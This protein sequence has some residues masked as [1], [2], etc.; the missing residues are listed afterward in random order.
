MYRKLLVSAVLLCKCIVSYGQTTAIPESE[1][2]I[3]YSKNVKNYNELL[4][5]TSKQ[6]ELIKAVK[7]TNTGH[8][9][10]KTM[11][12][13]LNLAIVNE[14]VL[15]TGGSKWFEFDIA[16]SANNSGTFLDISFIKVGY[17]TGVFGSS[18]TTNGN[19]VV[20]PASVLNIPS[21]NPLAT[22]V[23]DN[24]ASEVNLPISTS[25]TF[26]PL[27]R[28]QVTTTATTIMTVRMKIANCNQAYNLSFTSQAI[29]ANFS[30]FSPTANASGT[31]TTI[32]GYDNVNFSGNITDQSCQ[33]IITAWTNGVP[34]GESKT[35]SVTGKYFGNGKLNGAAL[36]F[37]NAVYGDR[38]PIASNTNKGGIQAIDLV[39]WNHNQIVIVLPSIIDSADAYVQGN[40]LPVLNGRIR[41]GSGKFK[42][43]N[44]VQGQAESSGPIYIPWNVTQLMDNHIII[45]VRYRKV[46]PRLINITGG[47]YR[48]LINNHINNAW[49][50][51][52]A[53]PVI[54]KAMK[55]WSCATGINWYIGGDTTKKYAGQ[56]GI[57]VIDTAN[58]GALMETRPTIRECTMSNGQVK[59]YLESF[60]IL[61]KQVPQAGNYSMDTSSNIPY[62]SYDFYSAISHELGH[63]HRQSHIND[64]IVDL[65]WWQANPYG[66][67]WSNRKL[68]KGSPNAVSGGNFVTDSLNGTVDD[69]KPGM[70]LI[71]P[72]NC[73]EVVGIKKFRGGAFNIS[74]YPNPSALHESV[75]IQCDLSGEKPV[76]ISLRDITGKEILNNSL[77]NT[78]RI[79]YDLQTKQIA[80]G[81]YLLQINIGA[82]TQSFKIMKQ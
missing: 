69:C 79:D 26:T 66:Y 11:S 53:K 50:S 58:I 36:V 37:K 52:A 46:Q 7:L 70:T 19:I 3:D 45:P 28:W 15:W 35:V 12:N 16:A 59:F 55:D 62:G 54:K 60:D 43:Y 80:S 18:V 56:D 42:V 77:G 72:A 17:N 44:C 71:Y 27:N 64:S 20:T 75:K 30:W 68:V 57:C 49:T 40:P 76:S 9:A 63:A 8:K 23:N 41:V 4:S 65:M 33:P 2:P 5:R 21:Y 39:S 67:A 81:L 48:V 22:L 73:G 10:S 24:T 14:R 25:S 61:I 82:Q 31:S 78:N 47:G 13:D 74:V 29:T 1:T 32:V 51:P 34:A 6:L 38:Y